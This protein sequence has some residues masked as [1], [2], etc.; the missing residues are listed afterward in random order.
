MHQT[1]VVLLLVCMVKEQV[2]YSIQ[3]K[4]HLQLEGSGDQHLRRIRL[5]EEHVLLQVC[6]GWYFPLLPT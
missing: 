5:A 2:N 1:T 4:E 6:Q 3:L